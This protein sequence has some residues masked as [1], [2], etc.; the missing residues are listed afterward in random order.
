M[1]QRRLE[2]GIRQANLGEFRTRRRN[3]RIG[4]E[5]AA[6]IARHAPFGVAQRH[7]LEEAD[8]FLPV[9]IARRGTDKPCVRSGKFLRLLL[10]RAPTIGF[11]GAVRQK[12][13]VLGISDEEQSK[14]D[15]QRHAVGEIKLVRTGAAQPPRRSDSLGKARDDLAIDSVAKS[16]G[17]IP[18]KSPR[19]LEQR[20]DEPVGIERFGREEHP[21]ISDVLIRQNRSLHL[22]IGLCPPS[23]PDA[24]ADGRGVKAEPIAM[25]HDNPRKALSIRLGERIRD[26]GQ[27]VEPHGPGFRDFGGIEQ[28][29]E[30][31]ATLAAAQQQREVVEPLDLES[32]PCKQ[33]LAF[34]R[35]NRLRPG[36]S[37]TPF[38]TALGIRG[39][40]V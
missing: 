35:G 20:G 37:R 13:A 1:H 15:R 32:E 3:Y 30:G 14:E 9:G 18:G 7:R 17:E 10:Q 40:S 22:D 21:E 11:V 34:A 29:R 24:D 31:G 8:N 4:T 2:R 6:I 23:P 16:N 12:I 39:Q 27:I 25:Q 28:D 36:A 19:R 38:G 5:Q 33:V 26:W